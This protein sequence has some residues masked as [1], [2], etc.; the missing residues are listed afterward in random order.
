M[1]VQLGDIALPDLNTPTTASNNDSS[2]ITSAFK[3]SVAGGIGS[4]GTYVK[5]LGANQLGSSLE[6]T[7][8]KMAE[9]AGPPPDTSGGFLDHP[10]AS[11]KEAVGNVL[12]SVAPTIAGRALGG[13][14]AGAIGGPVGAGVGTAIG[15]GSALIPMFTSSAGSNIEAQQKEH[16]EKAPD[17]G[18]ASA[19]AVGQT[20]IE[21]GEQLLGGHLFKIPG[22]GKLPGGQ[23]VSKA[24]Q[25]VDKA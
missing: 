20:A 21:Y 12:G 19:A 2:S 24:G 3:R 15:L 6:Q 22:L 8:A 17:V 7:G 11:A 10:V 25:A 18:K 16:P 23:L 9:A 13:L 1:P 5:A 4:T 14:A